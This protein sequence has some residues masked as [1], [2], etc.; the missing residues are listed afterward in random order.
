M[1]T[2]SRGRAPRRVSPCR[3]GVA[4]V[5]AMLYM[6]LFSAL[7]LGF[8][9]QITLSAQISG[10]ERRSRSALTAAE[11]GLAFIR[12]HLSA[13]SIPPGL[14]P[15]VAFEELHTQLVDHLESTGNLGGGNTV[16]IDYV[17]RTISVPAGTGN[18]VRLGCD[19]DQKFRATIQRDGGQYVVRVYGARGATAALARGIEVRFGRVEHPSTIWKYGLAARGPLTLSGGVFKGIPDASRG[20]ILSTATT[21]SAIS[22]SGSANI[23]GKVELTSTTSSVTGSGTIGGITTPSLWPV[24]KGVD[25]PE[26]PAVN[27]Q[28]FIDYMVGRETLITGSASLASYSNI[29]IKAGCNANLSGGPTIMGVVIV[30]V[31]NKVTF[32][33]GAKFQ[34][35]IVTD[36]TNDPTSTNEII[37]S[38]GG[39][40]TGPE[41][42]DPAVYGDLVNMGGGSILAPNFKLTMTGGSAS[43]GGTIIVKSIGL[44]GGSGGTSYGSVISMSTASQTWSGGS[45]FTISNTGPAQKP[46]G[47]EFTAYYAPLP[48]SYTE[49]IP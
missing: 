5:L 47:V 38:G 28:P 42:L 20:S 12:Y 29:R 11:S 24:T 2:H 49:F 35:V 18:Y 4:S 23:T 30:E 48:R 16:G 27:P 26:W 17:T 7:A 14:D 45:G 19:G 41:G 22:M 10:N 39:T 36:N 44:S 9:A 25:E 15:D 3:Q 6:V 43:F 37:F 1:N 8:Y 40:M 31:P 32:S 46:V 33:G 21:A 34:G 13:V